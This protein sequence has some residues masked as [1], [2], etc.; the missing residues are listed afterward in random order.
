MVGDL[1]VLAELP[2]LS[3]QDDSPGATF[4]AFEK[5]ANQQQCATDEHQ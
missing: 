2:K 1:A 3:L 5:P 4:C